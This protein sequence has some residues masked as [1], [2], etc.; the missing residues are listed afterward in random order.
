MLYAREH[1]NVVMNSF[2]LHLQSATQYERIE[3]VESFV[4]LDSSGSFGILGGHA[5][6]M[7][8]LVFG[9]A[10]FRTG[11]GVLSYLALP[12][13]LLYFM[14]NQLTINTRRYHYDADYKRISSVL[15]KEM[16]AEEEKLHGVK[17][18][19]R[20][21]EQAMLKRMWNMQAEGRMS[22]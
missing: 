19:L 8:S 11:N 10:R 15:E 2:V 4:G 22:M 17:E 16:L 14:D 3:N 7:T 9:L 20:Q 6:S 5:R 18:S 21:L 13:A 1:E 12:G